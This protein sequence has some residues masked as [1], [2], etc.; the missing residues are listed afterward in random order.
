MLFGKGVSILFP[1]IKE[2]KMVCFEFHCRL[3]M[4]IST[5]SQRTEDYF[6]FCTSI[7][8]DEMKSKK[9]KKTK[10]KREANTEV[11]IQ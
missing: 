6:L 8:V 2:E 5:R 1:A 7:M 9:K 11:E 4:E 10:A 3:H